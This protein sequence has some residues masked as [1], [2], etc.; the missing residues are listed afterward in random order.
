MARKIETM[1][2]DLIADSMIAMI[3]TMVHN[4][5]AISTRPSKI[6]GTRCSMTKHEVHKQPKAGR[7]RRGN[8]TNG[9]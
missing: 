5:I 8:K 6:T 7:L 3:A 2:I 9:L 4:P 1:K